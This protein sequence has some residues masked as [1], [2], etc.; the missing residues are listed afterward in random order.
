MAEIVDFE[1]VR[2]ERRGALPPAPASITNPEAR[3]HWTKLGEGL[4]REFGADNVDLGVLEQACIHYGTWYELKMFINENGMTYTLEDGVLAGRPEFWELSAA[5]DRL[6]ECLR[7]LGATP[8]A[9]A[10][11]HRELE[12]LEI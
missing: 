7:A 8:L 11:K 3:R 1:K 10:E 5:S 12:N 2:L 9:R 6:C 4:I